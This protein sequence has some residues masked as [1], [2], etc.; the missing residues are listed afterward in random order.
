MQFGGCGLSELGVRADYA[1]RVDGAI[2][3]YLEVKKP[4]LDLDPATFHG[5]NKQQW[6]QLRD[7]PD[8]IYTNG[9][10]LT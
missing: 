10:E 9:T 4:G 7:L 8:L 3:G 5:H 1:I 6:E 2:T